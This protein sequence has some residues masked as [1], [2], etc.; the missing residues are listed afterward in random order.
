MARIAVYLAVVFVLVRKPLKRAIAS[1]LARHGHV[2]G[3]SLIRWLMKGQESRA[4]PLGE[5]SA[6]RAAT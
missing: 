5:P 2:H 6:A 4:A 3:H 1:H